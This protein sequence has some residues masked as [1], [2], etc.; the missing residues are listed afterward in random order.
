VLTFSIKNRINTFIDRKQGLYIPIGIKK[1]FQPGEAKKRQESKSC[2]E[3]LNGNL[4]G[5]TTFSWKERQTNGSLFKKTEHC[6][7]EKYR[8]DRNREMRIC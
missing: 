5:C 3:N 2:I 4:F 6:K 8:S 1:T 7:S